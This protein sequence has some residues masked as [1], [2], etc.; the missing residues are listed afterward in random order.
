MKKLIYQFVFSLFVVFASSGTKFE[1]QQAPEITEVSNDIE[2]V[3]LPN[4]WVSFK[5]KN[6]QLLVKHPKIGKANASV[7]Y[8]IRTII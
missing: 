3:E 4:W 5:N 6:L 1:K 2:C 7:Y 8:F